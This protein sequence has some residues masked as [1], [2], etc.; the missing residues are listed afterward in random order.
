MISFY[1]AQQFYVGLI[2]I[3]LCFWVYAHKFDGA[4]TVVWLV[5]RRTPGT[6]CA[7]PPRREMTAALS[8]SKAGGV[9][10]ETLAPISLPEEARQ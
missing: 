3:F 4:L 5:S 9:P 1:L 2:N 6:P 7:A 8:K 10:H